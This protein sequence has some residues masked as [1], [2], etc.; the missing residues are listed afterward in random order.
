MWGRGGGVKWECSIGAGRTRKKE[1]VLIWLTAGF[2][3]FCFWLKSPLLI[4]CHWPVVNTVQL[5]TG[6]FL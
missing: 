4:A 5:L 1:V 6:P 3:V 2:F